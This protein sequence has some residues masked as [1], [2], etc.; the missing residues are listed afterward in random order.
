MKDVQCYVLF[1]GIALKNHAFSCVVS[2]SSNQGSV[3]KTL[4][5]CVCAVHLRVPLSLMVTH[6]P[7]WCASD[8][9]VY[10]CIQV[11][12]LKIPFWMV[13][14]LKMPMM[15]LTQLMTIWIML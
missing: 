8:V 2:L 14:R 10:F 9:H 12:V 13:L 15:S 7:S 6:D 11:S 4:F 1:G 3:L 5:V